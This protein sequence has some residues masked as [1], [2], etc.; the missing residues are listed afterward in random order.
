MDEPNQEVQFEAIGLPEGVTIVSESPEDAGPLGQYLSLRAVGN[1]VNATPG[2]YDCTF[3][4]WN[5]YGYDYVIN[6]PNSKHLL[7]IFRETCRKAGIMYQT[8]QIFDY[9]KE[10][11]EKSKYWQISLFDNK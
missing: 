3:R 10:F 11:P 9:L 8:D 1:S 4:L 6:S 2:V 7:H 5:K